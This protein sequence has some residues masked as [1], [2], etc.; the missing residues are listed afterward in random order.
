MVGADAV[1]VRGDA[2]QML[3]I[4]GAHQG[5]A[6]PGETSEELWLVGGHDVLPLVENGLG[7]VLSF[8]GTGQSKHRE[9]RGGDP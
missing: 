6:A 7:F 2:H 3:Y 8:A 9:K 5:V 4:G 1:D